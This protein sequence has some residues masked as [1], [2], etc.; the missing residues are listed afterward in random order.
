MSHWTGV[1]LAAGQGTRMRSDL[2][3]MLHTVCGMT[4][5]GHVARVM[6]ASGA[7]QIV[8]VA[9]PAMAKMPE[10]QAAIRKSLGADAT[11]AIQHE[12]LG[13]G[14]ALQSAR[15]AIQAGGKIVVGAGDMALV[16]HE[17]VLA[18]VQ[19][20]NEAGAHLSMLTA[21]VPD[22]AG[23]G[24]VVRDSRGEV[25]AVVEEAEADSAEKL[26]CEMNTGWFCLDADWAWD[27]LENVRVSPVGEKYLPDL[28]ASAASSGH[29]TTVS[30]TEVFEALG[31]NDRVQLAEVEQMMR[32]RVMR[33]H[34]LGG[35]TIRDPQTTYIDLDVEIGADTELLPGNHIYSGTRIGAHCKIGPNSM[36]RD[37]VIG[38]G[39]TVISSH[40][41]SA[42]IGAG[43]SV[44]PFSRI[45]AGTRIEPGA[46]IGNFAE[47]KNSKIGAGTHVGHFSY[48]GDADLGNDVNI[49]AG[50]VT[51]NFDGEDKHRTVI[52]DRVKIGSDTVIVAPAIIGDDANTGAGAVVNRDVPAGETVVGV[53]AKPINRQPSASQEKSD[54]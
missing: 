51:A 17:S 11:I 4:L 43:I 13:T 8:V 15:D 27:A 42:E 20:H 54:R 47:I 48:V 32:D 37:C 3:K 19:H 6:K 39:A 50:T 36:L 21:T 14:H 26:I 52:G 12:P 44:G 46:Y 25:S 53:P 31:V 2:P 34:M 45:R 16:R 24:R 5:V 1:I 10:L 7:D 35:V 49:G 29:A 38:D 30:V 33:R 18:L 9:S 23:F 22:P 28:V 41:E 40:I